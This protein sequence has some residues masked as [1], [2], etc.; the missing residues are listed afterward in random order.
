MGKINA[1]GHITEVNS[2]PWLEMQFVQAFM[3]VLV[4]CKSEEGAILSTIF[5]SSAQ[6]QVT[7]KAMDKCVRNSNLFEHFMVVLVTCKFDDDTINNQSQNLMQP[8][9]HPNDATHKI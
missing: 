1:Q 7:R 9:P 4:V 6:G 3:P 2:P 5:F 8:F